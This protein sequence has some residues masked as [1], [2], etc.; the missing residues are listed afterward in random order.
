MPSTELSSAQA[1]EISQSYSQLRDAVGNYRLDNWKILSTEQR[2]KL[3]DYE[4]TLATFASDFLQKSVSLLLNAPQTQKA[5]GNISAT[6]KELT[7]AVKTLKD[8]NKILGIAAAAFT[9]GG[10]VIS[11]NPQAILDAVAGAVT[12]VKG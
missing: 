6:T 2:Q 4:W 12:A 3:E 5:V 1:F 8:I 7:N 10:A 11:G 9:L